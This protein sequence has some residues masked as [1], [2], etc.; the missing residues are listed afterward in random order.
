[1]MCVGWTVYINGMVGL[2]ASEPEF[3]AEALGILNDESSR[4][5]LELVASQAKARLRE[6][7]KCGRVYLIP[8]QQ[9]GLICRGWPFASSRPFTDVFIESWDTGDVFVMR[10]GED[11]SDP[12]N[13]LGFFGN[14]AFFAT[15]LSLGLITGR[16]LAHKRNKGIEVRSRGFPVVAGD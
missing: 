9:Q 10:I 13:M 14:F 6:N 5:F 7:S 1:M 11:G 15:L 2:R 4:R 12:F 16:C 8:F 3:E